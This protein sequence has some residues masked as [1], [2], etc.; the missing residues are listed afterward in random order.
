[1][2]SKARVGLGEDGVPGCPTCHKLND[3]YTYGIGV[4]I[5]G[6]WLLQNPAFSGYSAVEAY[7]PSKKIAVSVAA[8]Y[9][10]EAYDETGDVRN[11]ALQ[12]FRD[13]G[14]VVAPDDAPPR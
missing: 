7:L 11:Q 12:L 10:P 8:T 3:S 9:E 2:V 1:M 13:I 6:D 14:A 4:V 5:S